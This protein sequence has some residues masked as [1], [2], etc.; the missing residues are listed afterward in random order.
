M[1]QFVFLTA[2]TM[3]STL[4]FSQ[5]EDEPTYKQGHIIDETMMLGAYNSEARYDVVGSFDLFLTTN[6]IYFQ[7]KE[8]NIDLG[9]IAVGD[10]YSKLKQNTDFHPG[11]KLGLGLNSSFDNWAIYAQY[12]RLHLKNTLTKNLSD[13]QSFTPDWTES[14]IYVSIAKGIWGIKSDILDLELSRAY[15]VGRKLSLA[16]FVGMR[17]IRLH[18]TKISE[19]TGLDSE[20]TNTLY[21]HVFN[22][23]NSLGI[24]P[25]VGINSN[26]LFGSG[27]R[28]F[29]NM[30][31]SLF[32]Q[33]FRTKMDHTLANMTLQ[34][35]GITK[36]RD[37]ESNITPN[38]EIA[39]G[40]G[41]GSYFC[42]NRWHM[43]I[44][45]S[46]E[47]HIF[48]NQNTP[49]GIYESLYSRVDGSP[50][51]LTFQGLNVGIKVD[52]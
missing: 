43:D 20:L 46:Y 47:F 11:F 22:R 38:L 16:P 13:N 8:K 40:F 9:L 33:H 12:T 18:Q 2:A 24:G 26:Y 36:I 35:T 4:L 41:W 1:R 42:K 30:A 14:D 23:A 6:F 5:K 52:F 28:L 29:G 45:A 37:K 48:W 49:R 25:R 39:I 21:I 51:A 27:T 7:A 44:F 31:A 32:Y 19:Y 10:K 50:A 15:Y 17:G 3:L 34:T